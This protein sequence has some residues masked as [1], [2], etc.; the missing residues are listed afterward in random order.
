MIFG[1]FIHSRETVVHIRANCK[2]TN[3]T[4]ATVRVTVYA[5]SLVSDVEAMIYLPN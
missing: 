5:D 4:L 2:H 3:Q 1:Y